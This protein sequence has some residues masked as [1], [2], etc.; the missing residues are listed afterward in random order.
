MILLVDIC[1]EKLHSLEF[2]EPIKKIVESVGCEYEVVHYNDLDKE[3]LGRCEKVI[4]CGT[5]IR[6]NLFLKD[7]KKF[8]W[9]S[10]FDKPIFGI[11]GGMHLV[12]LQFGGKVK[13]KKQIGFKEIIFENKFLGVEGVKN[14]YLLHSKFAFSDE[15]DIFAFD[16]CPQAIK[17]KEKDV[18][19][20]LFHPEVRNKEFILN[21]LS[22]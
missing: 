15:F 3:I 1:N 7:K 8:K 2:V 22:I 5:S 19:G 18:Y 11:C 16:G 13:T 12:A 10:N 14:V 20:V 9:I 4:I 6:D 17:H 21:F